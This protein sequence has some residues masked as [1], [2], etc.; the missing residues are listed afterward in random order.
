MEGNAIDPS[1]GWGRSIEDSTWK[2]RYRIQTDCTPEAGHTTLRSTTLTGLRGAGH[3]T[4]DEPWI[5]TCPSSGGILG[6]SGAGLP[7]IALDDE[8]GQTALLR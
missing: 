6:D 1:A 3:T 7:A 4:V 2:Y 5:S 8:L